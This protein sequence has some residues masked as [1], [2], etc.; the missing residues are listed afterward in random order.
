MVRT[1]VSTTWYFSSKLSSE[2]LEKVAGRRYHEWKE[3]ESER[4]KVGDVMCCA[5]MRCLEVG[6]EGSLSSGSLLR[7]GK[8]GGQVLGNT[9]FRRG[10]LSY[11][12]PHVLPTPRIMKREPR[13]APTGVS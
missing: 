1:F 7:I 11:L 3:L 6:H 9:G 8:W 4:E 12:V 2:V 5:V 10:E 13:P